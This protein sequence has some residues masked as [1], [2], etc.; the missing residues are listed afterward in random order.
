MKAIIYTILTLLMSLAGHAI[1]QTPILTTPTTTIPSG[2]ALPACDPVLPEILTNTPPTLVDAPAETNQPPSNPPPPVDT[3]LIYWFHGL[4]GTEESWKTAAVAI[5]GEYETSWLTPEYTSLGLNEA[6]SDIRNQ[7]FDVE[8][9]VKEQSLGITD[10]SSSFIIAHSQGGVVAR[11]VDRHFLDTPSDTR[12]YGG[13]VTFGTSHYGAQILNNVDQALDFADASCSILTA[14]PLAQV[15]EESGFLFFLLDRAGT[16]EEEINNISESFCRLLSQDVLPAFLEDYQTPITESY[17]VGAEEITT[18]NEVDIPIPAVAF[19][20]VEEEPAG[21][22]QIHSLLNPPELESA[23][24]ANEDDSFIQVVDDN[25]LR[26]ESAYR[27]WDLVYEA[28]SNDAC[29]WWMWLT[30][31][32]LCLINYTTDDILNLDGWWPGSTSENEAREIRDAYQEGWRWWLNLNDNYKS[33]FGARETVVANEEDFCRCT[34]KDDFSNSFDHEDILMINPQLGCSVFDPGG[35]DSPYSSCEVM[36]RTSYQTREY[37]FDGVVLK[38]SAESFPGADSGPDNELTG[39]NHQQ[40]RNDEN[41]ET[42]LRELF[43]GEHGRYFRT[44]KK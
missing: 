14:G 21:L 4:G 16:G 20:G 9:P 34:Y 42:E 31:P 35:P 27:K 25:A 44:N 30:R 38:S 5:E 2:T 8:V 11:A 39:S 32:D 23:F 40:M 33:L 6:Q 15:Q 28:K 36:T 7:F 19:Y 3:R 12:R 1:G 41:L 18:L 26:Y 10:P 29:E 22:R 37:P 13:L 17:K 24:S 43:A